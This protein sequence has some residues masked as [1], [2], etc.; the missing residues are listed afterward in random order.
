M[1]FLRNETV[2][3][4]IK[5][6]GYIVLFVG[7]AM[8]SLRMINKIFPAIY[9]KI[10]SMKGTRITALVVRSKKI[11]GEETMTSSILSLVQGF[12]LLLSLG[13]IYFAFILSINSLPWTAEVDFRSTIDAIITT[14][15]I[16]LLSRFAFT[17]SQSIYAYLKTKIIEWKKDKIKSVAF[18]NIELL[19]GDRIFEILSLANSG[20]RLF[21]GAIIVYLTFTSIFGLFEFTQAWSAQLLEYILSPLKSTFI[22]L[23]NYIPNLFTIIVIIFITRYAVKIV[24]LIFIEVGKESLSFAGFHSDWAEPTYK[25]VRFLIFAFAAVVIFPYLPGSG[26]QAFQGVSVFLGILFSLG[27]SSAIANVVAGIV[28]T[29]MRPFKLGDRVKIADTMGDVIEKT[30]LVTRMRTIKNV[31][32]TIPNAMVLG[33]HIINYSSSAQEKGLILHTSISIGYDV[34]WRT[35]HQ[36]LLASTEA[37]ENIKKDPKPFILQ[38]SLDDFYV[39]YELNA[40][41]DNPSVMA[42]TYSEL[43][44]NIQDKF[45]EAGVEIMSP[46]YGAMRDGNQTAIPQDYLPKEYTAPSFKVGFMNLPGSVNNPPKE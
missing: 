5:S 9:K 3:N 38:T 23:I 30:L 2:I 4:I 7:A 18:N 35:V 16:L 24:H 29:Y 36:L 13:I 22:T 46:H 33:A 41:T 39:S 45:N 10:L 17:W 32:I 42:R 26:S 20:F 15:F 14:L 37:T 27:S 43:H 31:D 40:Y 8:F 11:I 44:Q 12:R 28:L 6:A 25:I 19:S 21:V 34:S 1:D